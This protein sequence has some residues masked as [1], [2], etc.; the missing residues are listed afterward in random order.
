[1]IIKRSLV[2]VLMVG[3][4]LT[5]PGGPQV[6][7]A[8]AQSS[9][10]AGEYEARLQRLDALMES[11]QALQGSI[12]RTKFDLDELAFELAF[13]GPVAIEAWVRER[14]TFDPYEG[15]LRGPQGTLW[16]AAGNALDQAVLLARLMN[17][18]GYEARIAEGK[19]EAAEVDRLLGVWEAQF[20]QAPPEQDMVVQEV[21]N[22]LERYISSY[23]G[24][25]TSDAFFPDEATVA[26]P[27]DGATLAEAAEGAEILSEAIEPVVPELRDWRSD[28]IQAA[29]ERYFWVQYRVSPDEDWTNAHPVLMPDDAS[30]V[31]VEV[32]RTFADA[33][34][35]EL[36]HRLRIDVDLQVRRGAERQSV[37]I[38][39]P[40]ER[41]VANLALFP[42]SFTNTPD[43]QEQLARRLEEI[44]AG[45]DTDPMVVRE[46]LSTLLEDTDFFY[47][48]L[49]GA[50]AP[51][52]S[53]FDLRGNTV[54]PD[55]SVNP[56]AGVF[57]EVN[58]AV[59]Q[60]AGALGAIG[61]TDEATEALALEGQW[62]T[63]TFVRPEG[64]EVVQKRPLM[65]VPEPSEDGDAEG[66]SGVGALEL[67]SQRTYLVSTG[68]IPPEYVLDEMLT[69]VLSGEDAYRTYL[70]DVYRDGK[71]V[72][73]AQADL[74][75]ALASEGT[76]AGLD[77]LLLQDTLE[78]APLPGGDRHVFRHLPA[79][80]GMTAAMAVAA[81]GSGATLAVDIVA[82]PRRVVHAVDGEIAIDP[83]A[84]LLLGVW[85]TFAEHSALALPSEQRAQ[86]A[87][88]ADDSG[89]ASAIHGLS[90]IADGS[91]VL[92]PSEGDATSLQLD[93][94]VAQAINRD[95]EEG[96][97]VIVDDRHDVELEHA[98]WWRYR[99]ETGEML[100]MRRHGTGETLTQYVITLAKGITIANVAAAIVFYIGCFM[101]M[102]MVRSLRA[103]ADNQASAKL[104]LIS[105]IPG[106]IVTAVFGPKGPAL[107]AIIATLFAGLGW[108][109]P[110]TPNGSVPS[111]PGASATVAVVWPA[112]RWRPTWRSA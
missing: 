74:S 21:R 101:I 47:P 103:A 31:A 30:P 58:R 40:W 102:G 90:G 65:L 105:C 81:S 53:A 70:A 13:E 106:T 75:A 41:P 25:S 29:V 112:E 94:R 8:L 109:D 52:A 84:E 15:L 34:P 35:E 10:P 63:F 89:Y 37:S 59:S 104:P 91:T 23:E 43:N 56:A 9:T 98:S 18:A 55:A 50:M 26:A 73:T 85:D 27:F 66:G 57:A 96:F 95:L 24:G 107:A 45:G 86:L 42:I 79:M 38:M 108:E 68:G 62:I 72:T 77:L 71:D 4:L 16:A 99:A 87:G 67:L 36:Q 46:A 60:A 28:P 1:M 44:V 2:A 51:G 32:E 82:N 49:N 110:S 22:A 17:D 7:G 76:P 54:P 33:V 78:A 100:G 92:L 14:I 11:L 69:S 20:T 83:G 61:G 39:S 80:T 93:A 19:L 64:E 12:D 5:S 111:V 6:G 3:L 97:V 48:M 88:D